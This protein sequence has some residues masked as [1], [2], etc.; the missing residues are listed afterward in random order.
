MRRVCVLSVSLW[1]SCGE[2]PAL[3]DVLGVVS[4]N[5]EAES[6]YKEGF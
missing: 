2:S 3:W 6:L 5:V 4:E 1:M